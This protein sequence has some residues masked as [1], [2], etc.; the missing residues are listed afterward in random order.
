MMISKKMQD[1]MNKQINEE[2]FSA[3]LYLSMAAWAEKSNL[4][5]AASWMRKQSEEEM[6]HAMKFFNHIN[7]RGGEVEL[8]PVEGPQK[9]WTG[10]LE[11]FEASL[12]HEQHISAC[13]NDLYGLAAAEKDYASQV[14][15]Q[16]F[17][18]EQV[19][20][21]AS[22]DEVVQKL[23][24]VSGSKNGIFMVDRELGKREDD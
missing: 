24:M 18:E 22:V 8:H 21:E 2:L 9:D 20:E 6:E 11:V 12:A 19:E 4:T 14:F 17:I 7:E 13:I 15:L 5:G 23:K 3:Y 10:I 16:W 1:A